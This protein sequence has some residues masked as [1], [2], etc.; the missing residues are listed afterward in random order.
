LA[1]PWEVAIMRFRYEDNWS[2]ATD[3]DGQSL[4]IK[5]LTAAPVTWSYPENWRAA[6]PSPGRP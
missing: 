4:V 6:Q 1:L 3:G 2:P 5:E